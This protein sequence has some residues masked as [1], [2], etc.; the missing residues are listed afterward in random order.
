MIFEV[1]GQPM[2]KQR[3]KFT[4]MG[5]YVKVYTPQQTINYETQIK[6]SYQQQ[7]KEYF[8]KEPIKV[9][10]KAYFKIPK[11]YSF[12]KKLQCIDGKIRPTTKPDVDNVAKAVLDAL[13][14]GVAFENDTQVV[15]LSIEKWYSI[16]PRLLI[17]I[18][19]E[20][21]DAETSK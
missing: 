7:C 5:R 2:G 13:Q 14:N 3:P 9:H 18:E 21:E 17:S 11:S 15:E 19:K 20:Q 12:K 1:L 16:E 8:G 4:T 6:L 10:I